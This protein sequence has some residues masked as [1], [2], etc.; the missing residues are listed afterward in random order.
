MR[1]F[2]REGSAGTNTFPACDLTTGSPGTCLLPDGIVPDG[3]PC[4]SYFLAACVATTTDQLDP[5]VSDT[6]CQAIC[7][8]GLCAPDPIEITAIA[9]TPAT[10]SAAPPLAAPSTTVATVVPSSPITSRLASV[11][12][13]IFSTTCVSLRSIPTTATRPGTTA[14][15]AVSATAAQ[16]VPEESGAGRKGCGWTFGVFVGVGIWVAV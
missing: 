3:Q 1:G 5:G 12:T 8:D 6:T 14:T 16:T 7:V 9:T 4:A 13:R 10:V 15:L 2:R 11:S